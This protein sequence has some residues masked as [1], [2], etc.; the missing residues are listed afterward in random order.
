M[1]IEPSPP[2]PTTSIGSEHP[3]PAFA[4][5]VSLSVLAIPVAVALWFPD[6]A[7]NGLGMLIW[8]TALIPAFLLAY[9]RGFKGVAVAL[10]GGMV[11]VVLTQSIV[12]W[13][14]ISEPDWPLLTAI[15]VAY[16]AIALG[17]GGLSEL[18]IQ[19][20]RNAE[21]MS[22]VDP[23]T[24]LPNRRS[25]ELFLTREVA[26]AERGRK[27]TIVVFDLDGFKRVNDQHGHAA[28]DQ[29]LQ[30]FAAIL[31]SNT[32]LENVSARFGGEEF[33]SVL[34]DAT[35][36]DARIFATRVLDQM[37]SCSLPWG[38]QTASAGIAE[39]ELGMGSFELLIGAADLAM[40]RAKHAGGDRVAISRKASEA[41]FPAAHAVQRIHEAEPASAV[42]APTSASRIARVWIV[43]DDAPARATLKA[44]LADEGYSVWD[45]G[46]PV[47][48]VR[49]FAELSPEERPDVILADVLMPEMTGVRMVDEIT[50]ISSKVRVIYMTV[51]HNRRPHLWRATPDEDVIFLQKPVTAENLF[52]AFA[53]VA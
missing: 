42:G 13:S 46:N 18:L 23:L 9:Y 12:V 21:A 31:R 51:G 37:R 50:N 11:V 27:L 3:V 47:D 26:A 10:A 35:A 39:Y 1:R 14:G 49:H 48:A 34:R 4:L 44:M 30:A 19:E 45:T 43:D 32:R 24:Q 41:H 29:T 5:V 53:Q 20:R 36:A 22:L 17:I 38:P 25:L 2:K 6:W 8:L 52:A 16:L 28:G 40:Y 7:S 33:V 15:L